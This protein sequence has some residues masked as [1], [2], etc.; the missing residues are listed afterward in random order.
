ME[1][2]AMDAAPTTSGGDNEVKLKEHLATLNATTPAATKLTRAKQDEI[3]QAVYDVANAYANQGNARRVHELLAQVKPIFSYLPN[4][5]TAKIVHTLVNIVSR[6]SHE[7][8]LVVDLCLE[9]IEW[10]KSSDRTF[11]R[12]RLEARLASCYLD[13][14]SYKKALKV[15]SVLLA[16]IKR[17]DDKLLL[18]EVQLIESRVHYKLLNMA[19][20]KASLTAARTSANAIY[21]PPSLQAQIDLQAGILH[22]EEKDYKTAYSY[23]FECFEGLTAVETNST[24][25][26]EAM[27][28]LKYMLLSKIMLN[29]ISDVNNIIATK[30]A[31]GYTGREVQAMRAVANANQA[32]SLEQFY[33]AREDYKEDL[34]NDVFV[35]RNLN[36]LEDTLFEQNLCRIIEPFSCIEITHVAQLINLSVEKV[37]KKLSQMILDKKLKGILDQGANTLIMHEELPPDQTYPAA[38]ETIS[39]LNKVLDSLY[40]KARSTTNL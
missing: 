25:K 12:Q 16:E 37:E 32:R 18:L 26:K 30:A 21:C 6:V 22:A 15:L 39:A 14:G 19:K 29:S 17:F 11:L 27:V 34:T 7:Q 33:K 9:S 31:L 24:V 1:I 28:P 20:A 36:Q 13:M 8:E 23:F 5:K 2:D 4:A 3:E 35:D 10:A 40:Q 38:I